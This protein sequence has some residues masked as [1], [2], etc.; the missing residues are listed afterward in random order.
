[1]DAQSS[2]SLNSSP[3][4]SSNSSFYSSPLIRSSSSSGSSVAPDQKAWWWV[5]MALSVGVV[6][7]VIILLVCSFGTKTLSK[8]SHVKENIQRRLAPPSQCGRP[9]QQ[10]GPSPK[11]PSVYKMPPTLTEETFTAKIDNP[12]GEKAV[13]MVF[14]AWCGWSKKSMP[15]FAAAAAESTVSFYL[16]EDKD[17]KAVIQKYSIRGFPTFLKFNNGVKQDYKG[18]RSKESL[19]EFATAA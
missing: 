12:N 11:T 4:I 10:Q 6:A 8:N 5:L 3:L 19:L 18:D 17:A 15:T 13:V 2:R 9:H 16:L 14:G 1:M 7:L